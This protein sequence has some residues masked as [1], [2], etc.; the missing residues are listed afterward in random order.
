VYQL[1]LTGATTKGVTNCGRKNNSGGG[2]VAPALLLAL[3]A[4]GLA[5]RASAR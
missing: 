5:R 4:A 1:S 3:L 2:G